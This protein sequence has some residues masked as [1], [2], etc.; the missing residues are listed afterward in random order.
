MPKPPQS[1]SKV[2]V[3]QILCYHIEKKNDYV[4]SKNVQFGKWE[5]VRNTSMPTPISISTQISNPS[6]ETRMP[7]VK[8]GEP[9]KTAK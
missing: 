1:L 8:A 7:D 3:K 6:Q 2:L 5:Q 4:A 9:R